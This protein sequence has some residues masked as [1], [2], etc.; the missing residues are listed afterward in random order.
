MWL[1]RIS[2]RIKHPGGDTRNREQ[3][4][5]HDTFALM[6]AFREGAKPAQERDLNVGE[7]VHVRVAKAYGS[8]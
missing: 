3:Q 8:L 6:G 7:R 5:I 1:L 2:A 4:G